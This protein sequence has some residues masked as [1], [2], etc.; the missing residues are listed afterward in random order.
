MITI[1]FYGNRITQSRLTA[2]ENSCT[3]GV[4]TCVRSG[5]IIYIQ[6][7]R[8]TAQSVTWAER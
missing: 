5:G 7:S 4:L 3:A 8:Y 1:A 6:L 2:Q